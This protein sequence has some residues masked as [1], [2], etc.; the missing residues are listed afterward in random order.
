MKGVYWNPNLSQT[1]ESTEKP[2]ERAGEPVVLV[3]D[4]TGEQPFSLF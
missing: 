4:T 2:G 3:G 1:Q